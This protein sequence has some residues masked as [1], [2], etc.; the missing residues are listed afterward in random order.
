MVEKMFS[1]LKMHPFET[2][3]MAAHVQ[4]SAVE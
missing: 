3:L 4:L 1:N 2:P